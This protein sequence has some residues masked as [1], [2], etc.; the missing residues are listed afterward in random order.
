M[1]DGI[2]DTSHSIYNF[3]G[4]EQ[5]DQRV[6]AA[7]GDTNDAE[8][9][10][11]HMQRFRMVC[12]QAKQLN[13]SIWVIAFGSTLPADCSDCASSANQARWPPTRPR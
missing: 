3:M 1:T 7:I 13:A 6:S 8:L 10:S 4:I 5:N 2:M 11:R 12:N 9:D